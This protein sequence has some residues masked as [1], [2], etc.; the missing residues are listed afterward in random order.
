[1]TVDVCVV[2]AGPAGACAAAFA[3][4]SGAS[5]VLVDLPRT[6]HRG[7]ELLSGRAVHRLAELGVLE[8]IQR[9]GTACTGT[10]S[11]WATRN[12][13]VRPAVLDP[14]GSGWIVDRGWLDALLVGN[15]VRRGARLVRGRVVAVDQ[16]GGL[17]NVRFYGGGG[18]QADTVLVAT[19]RPGRLIG[20]PSALV[21]HRI[22][23]L[24]AELPGGAVPD[25][26]HQLLVDRAPEGWWYALSSADV[27]TLAFCTDGD[28]VGCGPTGTLDAWRRAC[29]TAD[30]LPEGARRQT[31][32]VRS[33]IIT[34]ARTSS[35]GAAR[36]IG[37]AALSVD[38]LSGHGIAL[39]MEGAARWADPRYLEWLAAVAA[40]NLIQER[41]AY[42][43]SLG[44]VGGRF[45]TRRTAESAGR[46]VP[47]LVPQLG[48]LVALKGDSHRLKAATSAASP[49]PQQMNHEPEGGLL[50][51]A[52]S[53]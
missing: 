28:L 9:G 4:A 7:L 34:A 47:Q 36:L 53:W 42:R 12:F 48:P 21:R 5:T 20:G 18:V 29:L 26:S 2:G 23:V 40:D 50:S 43:A 22:V 49:R 14:W 25:L 52:V 3:A 41:N 13:I 19:G 45:W 33:R 17:V 31:P 44:A 37:D 30:W 27:T 38:P 15:A 11:R 8:Q 24:T 32:R 39:G 51:V 1:M 46:S 6:A 10:V 16:Q 35:D